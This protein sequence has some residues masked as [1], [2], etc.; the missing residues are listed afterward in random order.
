[1]HPPDLAELR[2]STKVREALEKLEGPAEPAV[3]LLGTLALLIA[4]VPCGAVKRAAP[5]AQLHLR[6]VPQVPQPARVL[7][8]DGYDKHRVAIADRSDACAPRLPRPSACCR[9]DAET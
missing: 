4:H 7:A 9:K 5:D 1:M 3:R 8:S 6:V 2:S